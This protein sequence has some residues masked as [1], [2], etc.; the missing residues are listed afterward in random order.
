MSTKEEGLAQA[1]E[2]AEDWYLGL[3]G[4]HCA[5]ELKAERA[6]AFAAREFTEEYVVITGGEAQREMR[7]GS[8]VAAAQ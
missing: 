4:K 1:E 5:G 6:F 7:P 8:P 2:F 3:R